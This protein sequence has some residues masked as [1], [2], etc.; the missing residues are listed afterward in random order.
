MH[1]IVK[2]SCYGLYI[3]DIALL[4]P[5]SNVVSKWHNKKRNKVYRAIQLTEI[6]NNFL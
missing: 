5:H 1:H 4:K 3:S 6:N 2:Y